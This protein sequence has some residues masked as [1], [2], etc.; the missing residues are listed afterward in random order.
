MNQ[1]RDNVVEIAVLALQ[2]RDLAADRFE[3]GI[4]HRR[5]CFFGRRERD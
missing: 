5:R 2:F 3:N 1:A 4:V